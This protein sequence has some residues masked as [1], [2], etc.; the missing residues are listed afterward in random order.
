MSDLTPSVGFTER[1]AATRMSADHLEMRDAYDLRDATFKRWQRTGGVPVDP[2]S[3]YW[4]PWLSRVREATQRGVRIRRLRVISEPLSEY[5]RFE[6]FCAPINV[7]AGEDVR[8]LPRQ[9]ARDL[10]LPG[11]DGWIF[12]GRAARFHMFDGDGYLVSNFDEDDPVVA[13][14]AQAAF[15]AAWARAIPHAE[16]QPP[17]LRT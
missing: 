12:D 4:R 5:I 2:D 14:R 7:R 3:D 1:L 10:L 16:Y 6:H 15:E 11:T 8:W 13:A 9:L 17:R